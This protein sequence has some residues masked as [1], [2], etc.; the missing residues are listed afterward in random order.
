MGQSGE[1]PYR[2]IN[3]AMEMTVIKKNP[4]GYETW[5]YH[6]RVVTRSADQVILEAYFDRDD[7]NLHGLVLG[8][9]DRFLE[10]WYTNRWYNIFEIHAREDDSLRG[11]YCN[12]GRPA[13]VEQEMISYIDLCLDLLI[14]PDGRQVILDEA[15]FDALEISPTDR[16][17]ARLALTELQ[18]HFTQLNPGRP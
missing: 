9:G 2:K 11:W 12:I 8:R 18:T 1:R 6:G 7:L 16:K 4:Q 3:L 15:E 13:E 10:T 17:Q 14:F 5:R